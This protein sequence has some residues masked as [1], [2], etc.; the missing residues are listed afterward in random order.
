[1]TDVAEIVSVNVT[2][3][4]NI[5]GHGVGIFIR[6]LMWRNHAGNIWVFGFEQMAPEGQT[7]SYEMQFGKENGNIYPTVY[8]RSQKTND[9]KGTNTKVVTHFDFDLTQL[10]E[11]YADEKSN[12]LLF[13]VKYLSG[14]DAN[15]KENFIS[16][17]Q[18][19]VTVN[20]GKFL[21]LEATA[22]KVQ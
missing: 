14:F 6:A 2:E 10:I 4:L 1:M 16:F 12:T 9:I 5:I 21:E 18:N 19:P 13:R 11:E 17:H 22:G 8:L 7:F 20:V 3:R 15:G